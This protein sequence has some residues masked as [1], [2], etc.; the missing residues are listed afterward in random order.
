MPDLREL[1]HSRSYLIQI[2]EKLTRYR[3]NKLKQQ[4]ELLENGFPLTVEE[5]EITDDDF[6]NS[7]EKTDN[8]EI[9]S[10]I[11]TTNIY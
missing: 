9:L 3:Q 5:E 2:K 4:Q 6:S 1:I 7:A 10:L 8:E 11:K